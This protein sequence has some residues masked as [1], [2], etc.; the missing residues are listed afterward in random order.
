MYTAGH[1]PLTGVGFIRTLL[2]TMLPLVVASC[3]NPFAPALA[4]DISDLPML[5]DQRTI[6][7]LFQNFRYSYVFRD[8]L[9]Y[10]RLLDPNFTFVYRDYDKMLDVTWGRDED[11]LATNGL[12]SAVRSLD[13]VW[14]DVVVADG[15]SLQQV[16]SRGFILTITFTEDDIQRAQG[17]LSLRVQRQAV[18]EPW[19]I[20][21]WRDESNYF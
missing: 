2:I 10:G 3:I 20:I 14:N 16:I 19:K 15:D 12:F 8:T 18:S 11:M 13:L 4:T 6:P 7:G 21:Q 9:I 5:G 1:H 17:R